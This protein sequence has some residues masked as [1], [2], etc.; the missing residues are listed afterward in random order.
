MQFGNLGCGADA[1]IDCAFVEASVIDGEAHAA[2]QCD[3]LVYSQVVGEIKLDETC[4]GDAGGVRLGGRG[5]VVDDEAEEVV[6][7]LPE[8]VEACGERVSLAEVGA[9][10]GLASGVV[11]ALVP[12]GGDG[13]VG[14]ERV[15][16]GDIEVIKGCGLKYGFR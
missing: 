11:G 15:V 10:I 13:G 9:E 6:F 3:P 7:V 14:G 8:A 1:W 2:E 4:V 16:V 12:G 5:A